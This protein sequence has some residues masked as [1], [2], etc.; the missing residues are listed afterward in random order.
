ML[1]GEPESIEEASLRAFVVCRSSIAQNHALETEKRIIR[2]IPLLLI[3]DEADNASINTKAKPGSDEDTVTAI[4]GAHRKLLGAFDKSVYVGYTATPFANIFINP[5]SESASHGLDLFPRSFIINVKPP[6]NYVGPGKVFGID[7]D[8]DA[9]IPSRE[10]LPIIREIDDYAVAFPPKH[11]KEHAP[12]EL[13][14]SL[15]KAIRCFILVCAARFAR[16]QQT[17]HNSML[18]HVTRF[19]DVQNCVVELIK[20]ELSGLQKRIEFSDGERQPSIT[21]EFAELWG[22]EFVPVR[23][24]RGRSP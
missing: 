4:N 15:R 19:V 1:T 3:D 12:A 23:S 22:S 6:S 18:V 5:D 7:G 9:G 2:S 10:G 16:G 13:P 8:P 20:H 14:P 24:S 17:R 11:R 21:D